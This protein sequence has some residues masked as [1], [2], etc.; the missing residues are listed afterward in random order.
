MS[1]VSINYK[2]SEIASMD[3]SGTK[4]LTTRGKY[5]EDNITINYTEPMQQF[6]NFTY[7]TSGEAEEIFAR[8]PTYTNSGLET[9]NATT[10]SGEYYGLSIY[11]ESQD[12]VACKLPVINGK[13]EFTIIA[14]SVVSLDDGSYVEASTG[15]SLTELGSYDETE[16]IV[17]K[18]SIDENNAN[19]VLHFEV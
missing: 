9:I 14:T 12:H 17:Y 5:C 13:C 6:R 4:T 15:C 3:A 7:T 1:N 10:I 8:I 16:Y 19:L 18:V 11:L 2:G